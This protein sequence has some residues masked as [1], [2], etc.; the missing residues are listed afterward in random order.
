MIREIKFTSLDQA[1][2]Y[3]TGLKYFRKD[4]FVC[5]GDRAYVYKH[6]SRKKFIYLSSKVDYLDE[7]TMD[8][9]TVWTLEAL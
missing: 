1:Q 5:K 6:K 9:G 2:E 8:R 4:S 7:D 3:L